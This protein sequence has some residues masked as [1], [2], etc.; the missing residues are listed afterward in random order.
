MHK[1]IVDVYGKKKLLIKN[2]K[3]FIYCFF[4]T[5]EKKNIRSCKAKAGWSHSIAPTTDK[6]FVF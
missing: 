3:L 6:F 4:K 1:K 5:K 2:C